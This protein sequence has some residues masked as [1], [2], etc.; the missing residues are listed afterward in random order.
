MFGRGQYGVSWATLLRCVSSRITEP[1]CGGGGTSTRQRGVSLSTHPRPVLL[2]PRR[3]PCFPRAKTE[4]LLHAAKACIVDYGPRTG[5]ELWATS[6]AQHQHTPPGQSMSLAARRTHPGRLPALGNL[7]R[8]IVGSTRRSG[9]RRWVV[10]V[11]APQPS[12]SSRQWHYLQAKASHTSHQGCAG[13]CTRQ[14]VGSTRSSRQGFVGVG[15]HVGCDG[16]ARKVIPLYPDNRILRRMS[17]R[18]PVLLCPVPTGRNGYVRCLCSCSCSIILW[19]TNLRCRVDAPVFQTE[20]LS[21]RTSFRAAGLLARAA[22]C[23]WCRY[24]LC[25]SSVHRRVLG[26]VMMMG[27]HDHVQ[28]P[29]RCIHCLLPF[30]RP[31]ACLRRGR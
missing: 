8:L 29:A 31:T 12:G 13:C 9:L 19:S 25:I 18:R 21:Y 24:V 15:R 30:C 1:L 16:T 28:T 5:P 10:P 11:V 17:G 4:K 23:W 22:R 27:V 20:T 26:S 6:R 7:A 2:A 14:L 3:D